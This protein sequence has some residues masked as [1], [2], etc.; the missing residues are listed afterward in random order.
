MKKDLEQYKIFIIYTV[1]SKLPVVYLQG[2]PY[3]FLLK[4]ME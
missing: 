2:F 3:I 4:L 1:T